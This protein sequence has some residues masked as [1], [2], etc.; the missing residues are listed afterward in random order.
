MT[1]IQTGVTGAKRLRWKKDNPSEVLA[2]LMELNPTAGEGELVD[3][4]IREGEDNSGLNR[5]IYEYFVRN[6]MRAAEE[7]KRDV[8]RPRGGRP[9]PAVEKDVKDAIQDRFAEVVAELCALSMPNGKD[10]G[11]CTGKELDQMGKAVERVRKIVPANMTVKEAVEKKK[12]S[13]EQLEALHG[14]FKSKN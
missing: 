8:R 12:L 1:E 6:G 4:M 9:R 2:R 7:K 14:A 13:I 3:K 5:S 11:D 10:L